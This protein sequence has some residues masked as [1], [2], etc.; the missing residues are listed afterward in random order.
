VALE[1]SGRE[2]NDR[3]DDHQERQR[4]ADEPHERCTR[5]RLVIVSHVVMMHEETW[6]REWKSVGRVYT[7]STRT[8]FITSFCLICFMCSRPFTIFPNTV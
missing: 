4:A 8:E 1:L 2:L 5:V 6:K 7:T 3:V